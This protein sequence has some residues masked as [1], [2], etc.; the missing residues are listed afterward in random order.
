[1]K[2][3][4]TI[5]NSGLPINPQRFKLPSEGPL[6]SRAL[7]ELCIIST[8]TFVFAALMAQ[9]LLTLQT[10]ALLKMLNY[11]FKYSLFGV[12]YLSDSNLGWT[13]SMIVFAFGSG[14]F[15]LSAIGLWLLSVC[16]KL[17]GEGWKTKLLF[18]WLA[19]VFFNALPCGIIAGA[20]FMDS[21]GVLFSWFTSNFLVRGMIALVVLF[22]LIIFNQSWLFLFLRASYSAVLVDSNEHRKIFIRNV[23]YKPLFFGFVILLFFN[24]PFNSFYWPLFLISLGTVAI[25]ISGRLNGTSKIYFTRSDKK[26]FSNYSQIVYFSLV[27]LV[28]WIFNFSLIY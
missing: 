27:L 26:I 23:L 9:F 21:F 8:F 12:K 14:P 19:F 18:S 20:F 6:S 7:L 25:P 3:N 15:M 13:D 24:L 22:V 2:E 1:M 10:A 16:K 11:P 5:Q 17:D 28:I 4:I